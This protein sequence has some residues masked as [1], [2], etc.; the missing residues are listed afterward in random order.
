MACFIK[1]RTRCSRDHARLSK[2]TFPFTHHAPPDVEPTILA[3]REVA[4]TGAHS[5]Q[6]ASLFAA[7]MANFVCARLRGRGAACRVGSKREDSLTSQPTEET[8][9]LLGQETTFIAKL[10]RRL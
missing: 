6:R 4:F 9:K 1:G 10:Y 2:M 7:H 5:M 8:A 3:F